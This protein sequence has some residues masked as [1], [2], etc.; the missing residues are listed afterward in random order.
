MASKQGG[1]EGLRK[2]QGGQ[3]TQGDLHIFS[4]SPRQLCNPSP[5]HPDLPG[6]FLGLF[7]PYTQGDHEV[8]RKGKAARRT[9]HQPFYSSPGP[10]SLPG[11]SVG[12]LGTLPR[13]L[14]LKPV[15]G[16]VVCLRFQRRQRLG[17][18]AKRNRFPFKG[19]CKTQFSKAPIRMWQFLVCFVR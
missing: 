2:T 10:P 7:R 19:P 16:R 6:S 3:G 13:H 9:P 17:A 1:Q 12:L 8:Q 5:G 15:K 4:G 14:V 18:G 11:S